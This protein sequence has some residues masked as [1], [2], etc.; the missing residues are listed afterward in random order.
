MNETTI[1]FQV[2]SDLSDEFA[3]YAGKQGHDVKQLLRDFM[4]DYV[5]HRQEFNG[6]KAWFREQVQI[7]LD[8]ANEGK[9]ISSE[10]AEAQAEVWRGKMRRKIAASNS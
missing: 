4:R 7:G 9:T 10:E 3:A 5:A 2:D 8:E 1:S 6:Y